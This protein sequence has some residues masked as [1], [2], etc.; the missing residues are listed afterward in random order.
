MVNE[1][2][3][4]Y[5]DPKNPC[6]MLPIDSTSERL[7]F[8]IGQIA[9]YDCQLERYCKTIPQ[10]YVGRCEARKCVASTDLW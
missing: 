2:C 1:D 5:K 8:R 4:V 3:G 9:P 10:Q 7:L 6:W